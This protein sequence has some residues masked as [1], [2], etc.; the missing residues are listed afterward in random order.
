[1]AALVGY[2]HITAPYDG[3]VVVRNANTGDYVQPGTGDQSGR[4]AAGPVRDARP[5]YVVA[6]TDMVRVYVDVPEMDANASRAGRKARVRIQALDDAEIRRHGHANLVVAA[7][8]KPHPAGRDRSAQ[9]GRAAAARHVRLRQGADRT[10]ECARLPLAAVVEIGNQN[11]CYLYEDGKAVQTPVQT[12]I[13]DGKWVEVAKK[14]A[15]GK[16]TAVHRRRSGHPRRPVGTDGRAKSEG[17]RGKVIVQ[18]RRAVERGGRR[19]A[20]LRVRG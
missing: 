15:R 6:R 4:A 20:P 10:Q 12:G 7:T 1:M 9:P 13:N 2:T 16:W 5:L 19:R 14:R 8:R 17:G 11:C 3:V 18:P